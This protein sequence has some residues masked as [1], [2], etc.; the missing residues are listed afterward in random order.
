MDRLCQ[1]KILGNHWMQVLNIFWHDFELLHWM[2]VDV[3]MSWGFILLVFISH[4]HQYFYYPCCL[5]C[6]CTK[7]DFP[8]L[9]IASIHVAHLQNVLQRFRMS[10]I[11]AVL[12]LKR[13][14]YFHHTL[15]EIHSV[16]A[17]SCDVQVTIACD[18]VLNAPSAYKKQ[19]PESWD[20]EI[21]VSR[22]ARSLRQLD[23]G[24]RIPPR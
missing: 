19:E 8:H 11:V 17:V 9:I 18:A 14:I 15:P 12:K 13:L 23:N 2:M 20:E 10:T 4:M 16:S 5:V 6:F 21:Q 22:H 24:V 7:T 1:E 3:G